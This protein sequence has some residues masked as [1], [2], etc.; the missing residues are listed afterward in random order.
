MMDIGDFFTLAP[1]L[2]PLAPRIE[3]AAA[4]AQKYMDD[5]AIKAMIA[6]MA[7][8]MADPDIKDAIA[9]GKEVAQILE[10]TLKP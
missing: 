6:T 1:K 4:T 9:V 3:K 7:R 5:P 2:S 10:T 8:L